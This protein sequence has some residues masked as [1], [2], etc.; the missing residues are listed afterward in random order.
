MLRVAVIICMIA[1][2]AVVVFAE[3]SS[4]GPG[5]TAAARPEAPLSTSTSSVARPPFET[6]PPGADAC[7][8][9]RLRISWL[10]HDGQIT[11]GPVPV[12]PGTADTHG[13]EVTPQ[14]FYRVQWKA[15]SLTSD[16]FDEP[17][18]FAVFFAP[19]GVAFHEGSLTS[20]SHGCVHLSWADARYYFDHLQVGANV[21]VFGGQPPLS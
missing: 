11:Y 1:F 20:S 5:A 2:T 13:G 7:V 16:E 3:V 10:Q 21:A 15:V 19:G 6:C 9:T 14:G 17:M 18:P 8:D 4:R 12:M